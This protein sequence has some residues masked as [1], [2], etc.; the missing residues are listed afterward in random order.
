MRR[1]RLTTT[2]QVHVEH[3]FKTTPDRRLRDRCQAVL[4]ASRGRKRKTIAQDLGVHRTTV[5]L[6]LVVTILQ[7]YPNHLSRVLSRSRRLGRGCAMVRAVDVSAVP[8]P[9]ISTASWQGCLWLPQAA[10][11]P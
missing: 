6:W 2:E 9:G 3:L 8:A 11:T 7:D 4:M 5:R 10:P 1:I